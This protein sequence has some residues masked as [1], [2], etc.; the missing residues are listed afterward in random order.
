MQPSDADDELARLT[1]DALS[2]E[3]TQTRTDDLT[4]S[5]EEDEHPTQV[6]D[7]GARDIPTPSGTGIRRYELTPG[8]LMTEAVMTP[9]ND[10]GPFVLDGGADRNSTGAVPV[11][12]SLDAAA[13]A[14]GTKATS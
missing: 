8:T 7:E 5:G 13:S 3:Q 14:A 10:V 11:A 6:G 12:R 2:L 4:S 1:G 9:R